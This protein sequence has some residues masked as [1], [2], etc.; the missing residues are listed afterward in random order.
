MHK[1]VKMTINNEIIMGLAT[2]RQVFEIS[3]TSNTTDKLGF[4][5]KIYSSKDPITK[6]NLS[7]KNFSVICDFDIIFKYDDIILCIFPKEVHHLITKYVNILDYPKDFK[8]GL[9]G[10]NMLLYVST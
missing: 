1:V 2:A 4:L 10:E 7:N 9:T 3:N 8:T 6:Q 5:N